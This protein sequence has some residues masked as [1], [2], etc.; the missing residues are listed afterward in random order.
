[1]ILKYYPSCATGPLNAL[2]R[3]RLTVNLLFQ[4]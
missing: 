2:E 1:M 4:F 3:I